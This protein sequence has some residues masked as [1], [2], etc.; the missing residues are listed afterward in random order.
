M[1]L[2]EVRAG[3]VAQTV[4]APAKVEP[5]GRAA[6][7]A[8]GGGQVA[9]LF[10]RDGD[11][12]AAGA[13]VLRLESDGVELA[14]TQA[15][16][17]VEASGAL[18]AVPPAPN[19]SPII[20]VIRGQVEET[21]PPLLASAEAAAATIPDPQARS[22]ALARVAEAHVGYER[23]VRDLANAEEKARSAT[24]RATA[25]QRRAAEAQRKQAEAALA[26]ARSR[27]ADL[28]VRAPTAG[29]VEFADPAAKG[30]PSSTSLPGGLGD[31]LGE[32]ALSVGGPPAVG[33]Q[34][35]PGQPLFS[36][37]DLSGFHVRAEV[38]EVD[39][40]LVT[41]GQPVEI[42]VDAYPDRTFAGRVE[43]MAV[44]PVA[45]TAGSVVYPVFVVFDTLPDD[46]SLRVGLTASIEVAV[47]RVDSGTLVPAG[48]L[49]RRGGRD[50]V[51]VDRQGRAREVAVVPLAVGADEAA[52]EG[53][54]AVGDRVIIAGFEQVDDGD[55][56]P[57]SRPRRGDR[58]PAR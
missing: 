26:A 7:A 43:R 21:V 55:P 49:L 6:V 46:I 10:V 13:P 51:L 15:R 52:V 24:R 27:E 16:A 42:L 12:V 23:T 45:T 56:L 2:A 11:H 1:E 40:V 44:A 5:A 50:V 35:A 9:E 30:N 34:T 53:G 48:A 3:A 19:V 20:A 41:E 18:A 32:A 28:V 58:A 39:A 54:L 17:G 37:Y 33:A 38:D 14:V 36:V 4:A 47:K 29:I 31:L 22:D 57:D 8:P 25:A